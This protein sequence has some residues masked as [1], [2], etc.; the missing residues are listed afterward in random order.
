MYF[1]DQA[2]TGAP[3]PAG[4]QEHLAQAPVDLDGSSVDDHI[5]VDTPFG[6]YDAGLS[7]YDTDGDG[8][9]DTVMVTDLL[10]GSVL[11]TDADGDGSADVATEITSGGRI[12]V[13]E[14]VGDG[15][16]TVVEQSQLDADDRA[17]PTS[18]RAD[19]ASTGFGSASSGSGSAGATVAEYRPTDPVVSIDPITGRWTQN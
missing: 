16:W 4:D 8:R 7:T 1:E 18:P 3:V 17:E 5:S 2:A 10:S 11:Y 15:Q 13:S 12:I 14:H 9:N 6:S 19:D